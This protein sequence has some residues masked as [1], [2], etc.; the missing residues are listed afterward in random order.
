MSAHQCIE[1]CSSSSHRTEASLLNPSEDDLR[2][3]LLTAMSLSWLTQPSLACNSRRATPSACF[4][5]RTTFSILAFLP[6]AASSG[7][8]FLGVTFIH[9][10]INQE[11][12]IKLPT[13]RFDPTI[14]TTPQYIVLTN[15]FIS[16]LLLISIKITYKCID[17]N[18]LFIY[19]Y[20]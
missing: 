14:Y 17:F 16:K 15:H 8:L 20:N 7:S 19:I 6:G 13:R 5:R 3:R 2:R 11:L 18:L 9:A 4:S 12:Y 1:A 10:K